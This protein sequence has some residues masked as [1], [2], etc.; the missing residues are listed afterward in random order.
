VVAVPEPLLLQENKK[1]G[2]T[3]A[4]SRA[5]NFTIGYTIFCKYGLE[6]ASFPLL[7]VKMIPEAGIHLE[8][9]EHRALKG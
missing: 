7:N 1:K 3:N 2:K 4:R 9:Q 5:M 8:K 6:N